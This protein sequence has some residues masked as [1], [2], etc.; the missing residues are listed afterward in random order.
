MEDNRVIVNKVVVYGQTRSEGDRR[1]AINIYVDTAFVDTC[2]LNNTYW[3]SAHKG[4][5]I[6]K[7]TNFKKR[8]WSTSKLAEGVDSWQHKSINGAAIVER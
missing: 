4:W 6:W 7:S 8:V 1:K 2:M 3:T 5:Q